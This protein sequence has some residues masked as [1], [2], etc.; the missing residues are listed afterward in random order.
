MLQPAILISQCQG[1]AVELQF[2][3]VVDVLA[4]T[5]FMDSALPGAQ[6]FFVV[7][8]VERQHGRGVAHFDEALARL[9]AH[10]LGGGIRGD[11]FRV[12]GL[13]V[14]KL[15]GE[16]VEFLVADFRLIENE[17]EIFEMADFIAEALRLFWEVFCGVHRKRLYRWSRWGRKFYRR[18]RGEVSRRTRR[19]VAVRETP[20]DANRIPA[21]VQR[22]YYARNLYPDEPRHVVIGR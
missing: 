17:V 4:A 22:V 3:D 21:S 8:V 7:G 9:A 11:E 12:L 19:R 1:H 14:F 2:A 10:A 15:L 16:L 20:Q 6:L 13:E 5:Q 18:G